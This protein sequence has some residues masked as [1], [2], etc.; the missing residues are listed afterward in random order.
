MSTSPVGLGKATGFFRQIIRETKLPAYLEQLIRE[1]GGQD[2]A[3]TQLGEGP[4]QELL[5]LAREQDPALTQ[6]G[7]LAFAQRLADRD[8]LDWALRLYG[9]VRQSGNLATK[10]EQ[11][12]KA[13]LGEGV[14]GARWEFLLKRLARE[15]TDYRSLLPMLAGSWG[16][17]LAEAVV[18]GRLSGLT[19]FSKFAAALSGFTAELSGFG[20][21]NHAL[22]APDASDLPRDLARSALSLG[23]LRLTGFLG[24]AAHLTTSQVKLLAGPA[25][26]VLPSLSAFSGLWLARA[27]ET[28]LGLRPKQEDATEATDTLA[29][30]LSLTAGAR[31]GRLALG[32]GFHAWRS[33]LELRAELAKQGGASFL[34]RETR[35]PRAH[36]AL[37]SLLATGASLAVLT[38]S[39]FAQ[40][41]LRGV[42][43]GASRGDLKGFLAGVVFGAG[44]F[45]MSHMG[46]GSRSPAG[47]PQIYRW[48]GT[49]RPLQVL[50]SVA[51]DFAGIGIQVEV[52]ST[53]SPI[54]GAIPTELAHGLLKS[55][56][57]MLSGAEQVPFMPKGDLTSHLL[58]GD[59]LM[60][61]LLTL[62]KPNLAVKMKADG[63]LLEV[64]VRDGAKEV[65][66]FRDA[67]FSRAE[68]APVP[69]PAQVAPE[70]A[71]ESPPERKTIFGM[72]L[73]GTVRTEAPESTVE[74]YVGGQR[75]V[76]SGGNKPEV[77]EAP[78]PDRPSDVVP[79]RD[80][81][82]DHPTEGPATKPSPK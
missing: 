20:L 73:R 11:R 23:A 34:G 35:A 57:L 24:K 63:R 59:R 32:N 64:M 27:V 19:R 50:G 22:S 43:D 40:A 12:Q 3:K 51:G 54:A 7:L 47:G 29:E 74:V 71:P 8:Q 33:E 21:L 13:I 80:T 10:A 58:E 39:E 2:S 76:F 75:V 61:L 60:N 79:F 56:K 17:G 44:V 38:E 65:Q 70:P 6:E 72:A 25:N 52:L 49:S 4:Y 1:A 36:P 46:G 68:D 26:A 42:S 28:R 55:F 30:L 5:S 37:L 62:R 31:L 14:T 69:T 53:P 15:A 77:L 48:M 82:E 45:A 66:S 81:E 9:A 78:L 41:A 67:G 16:G 18:F